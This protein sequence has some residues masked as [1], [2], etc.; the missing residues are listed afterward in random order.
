MAPRL[1]PA[2][3]A[4]AVLAAAPAWG[5]DAASSG[6]LDVFTGEGDHLSNTLLSR[7]F[8]CRLFP[9]EGLDCETLPAPV[10]AT[11]VYLFN[12]F[13]LALGM[14][15]FTWNAM[16]G[17]AQTAH[18]GQVLGRSWSSLWAPVRT[19][20][21]AAMLTPLPGMD[22]YNTVQT[23]TA[24]LVRGSTAGAS[25]VW[26]AAADLVISQQ[27]PLTSPSTQFDL[28]AVGAAW[29]M[30][31]CQAVVEALHNSF[32]ANRRIA[33]SAGKT[34]IISPP[35]EIAP[36]D[37]GLPQ[38]APP[39]PVHRFGTRGWADGGR[40]LFDR[41]G[42]IDL[43]QPPE[44][45]RVAG[46]A[47]VWYRLHTGAMENLLATLRQTAREMVAD[48][49]DSGSAAEPGRIGVWGGQ[50]TAAGQNYR[51]D[52]LEGL[53]RVAAA[54]AMAYPERG[55]GISAA[56]RDRISAIISGGHSAACRR[57]REEGP[58]DPWTDQI[59]DPE[60][61]GQGWLGAGA[62][63]M[64]MARFAG[65]ANAV[66]NAQPEEKRAP[67][68]AGALHTALD[69]TA[70]EGRSWW[71]RGLGF[72][73]GLFSGD[74]GGQE[75]LLD[76]AARLEDGMR[77]RWDAAV[78]SQMQRGAALDDR[79]LEG[80]FAAEGASQGTGISA[81]VRNWLASKT[82]E[83]FL[84]PAT[85][86]PMARLA[87]FG[88]AQLAWGLGLA[89]GGWA[90]QQ[91]PFAGSLVEGLGTVAQA[92]GLTLLVSGAFLAFI[93]PM[94]PFLLW[95]LAATGY[96]ILI[97]E[98]VV[99]V[100]LWAVAHLRM[101]GEGFAGEAARQGYYIVLALTL[102]PILMVVGFMLGMALFKVSSTLVGIG[103][104]AA[105]RGLAH[106]QSWTVWLVG[107]AVLAV[108]I[109][110]VYAVMAERS[111]SLTAEFPNAALRWIGASA[112]VT[113][114]EDDRM[115]GA[116]LAGAAA[117]HSTAQ[118]TVAAGRGARGRRLLPGRPPSS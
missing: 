3:A 60:N 111:F 1:S 35:S 18:E 63:Y 13:C 20:A 116:A 9:V 32:V 61:T 44:Q 41:C 78:I 29:R 101:D 72:V 79:L 51:T 109:V 43:P 15:L 70:A 71:G 27:A 80:A 90:A 83:W 99:A 21:A 25:I 12:G 56:A 59:C 66:F 58:A 64:H 57:Q 105:M 103:F 42:S 23:S 34:V 49:G 36:D 22:G 68:I 69:A 28:A 11:V 96:F 106:D 26:A 115:R 50:I 37:I 62:W 7:I 112:A 97:A 40:D 30:A 76:E 93:L 45:V 8:G 100:N 114:K 5:Q 107:Q 85:V 24:W 104:D 110:V 10:F 118:T 87:E 108:M 67:K 92:I 17:V 55:G 82:R 95:T 16:V 65:E 38:P 31:S 91:I 113:S 86:D 53:R 19:L 2:L 102:T 98:A 46:Q 74:S 39:P 48:V 4:L 52:L 75:Q 6:I 117:L 54:S 94:M 84:P 73:S 33:L 47:A 14:A 89:G 77:M 88:N 81:G